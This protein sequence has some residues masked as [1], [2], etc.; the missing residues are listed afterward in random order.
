MAAATNVITTP[1]SLSSL[2][3]VVQTKAYKAANFGYDEFN[4]FEKSPFGKDFKVIWS[5][6]SI[7]VPLSLAKGI[8][9]SSIPEGGYEARPSSPALVE[10]TLAFIMLN[11]RITFSRLQEILRSRS[12]D[13]FVENDL[14]YQ[15][16]KA[17]EAFREKFAMMAYGFA[18][19]TV[20]LVPGCPAGVGGN[21]LVLRDMYGQSGL[22]AL[23]H[24][25]QVVDQFQAGSLPTGGDWIGVLNPVGP[26]L[27]PHGIV[28]VTA[29]NRSTNTITC[30]ASAI[31]GAQDGDI[32][33]F[34]NNNENTTLA[35]G[36]E[37]NLNLTRLL[38]M[39]TS[40]SLHNISGGP[41][42]SYPQWSPGYADTSGGK[43]TPIKYR[44]MKQGIQNNGPAGADVTDVWLAQ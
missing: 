9:T 33:V 11:K 44:K 42:G 37:R 20:A 32:I 8:G 34:A 15:G 16:L 2:M 35:G 7:L 40:P 39:L 4:E 3:R 27:R 13:A 6:P 31:T 26:S 24:N 41:S 10:A 12:K 5:T 14:K 30:N 23:T 25:R 19:G 29:K 36:T 22:G 38:D 18:S 17:V 43:F 28:Q 1:S 21:D